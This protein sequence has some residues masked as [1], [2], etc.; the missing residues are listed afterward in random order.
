MPGSGLGRFGGRQ[1]RLAAAQRAYGTLPA[2]HRRVLVLRYVDG[3]APDA[4]ADRLA[5]TENEVVDLLATARTELLRP[6]RPHVA[7]PAGLT[8]VGVALVLT[9]LTHAPSGVR[10]PAQATPLP[11]AVTY[12]VGGDALLPAAD[13]MDAA[14]TDIG[15]GLVRGVWDVPAVTVPDPR[16]PGRPTVT[17]RSVCLPKSPKSGDSLRVALPGPVGDTVGTQ[18]LSVEQ[19][20]VP[21]CENVPAAPAGVAR[22]VPGST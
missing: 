13:A 16:T 3:L 20:E 6:T 11:G 4:V 22:C 15:T 18:E 21:M 10:V 5:V 1:R 2:T 7:R 17:C 12:V 8:A 9:T 19:E 14:G